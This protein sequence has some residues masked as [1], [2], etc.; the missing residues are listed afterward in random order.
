MGEKPSVVILGA[1]RDRTKFGNKSLRA[2][3]RN[4][5]DVFPI[6]P[7]AEEIEG[8]AAFAGIGDLPRKTFNRVSIYLPPAVL[9]PMLPELAELAVEEIYLNPGSESPEVIEKAT[10]LNLPIIQACSIIDVGDHPS[11]L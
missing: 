6:N 10:A 1:S 3:Q 2:H 8:V 11:D 4:G 5:Y 9:L 7:H